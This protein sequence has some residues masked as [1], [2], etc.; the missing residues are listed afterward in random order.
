MGNIP[1]KKVNNADAGDAD[2]VG[3]NDW[4]DVVDFLN[5]ID[6]TGPVIL[7]TDT[8]VRSGKFKFRDTGNNH[9]YTHV[10]SDLAADR[11][12]TWPL[13]TGNDQVTFDA[14]ATTLTN[15]TIDQI[16]NPLKIQNEYKYVVF[17]DAADSNKIKVINQ[18]TGAIDSS[19]TSA[20]T[21]LQ[22][23]VD[24]AAGKP[25]FVKRGTYTLTAALNCVDK[26]V[27]MVGESNGDNSKTKFSKAGTGDIID[28]ENT[29]ASLGDSIHF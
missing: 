4:D 17:I 13:L 19:S 3:G 20:L 6:K 18:D 10:F 15:K 9:N 23:A 22:Y 29:S 27:W 5:D 25:I 24:N 7:N 21:S 16:S 28:C 11:N 26:Y 12:V 8:R 14:H 1:P 2:H